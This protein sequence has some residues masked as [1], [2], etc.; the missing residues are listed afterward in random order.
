MTQRLLFNSC[1]TYSPV[2]QSG[3][4]SDLL[5]VTG[6]YI[7]TYHRRDEPRNSQSEFI[8]SMSLER[9]G[10]SSKATLKPRAQGSVKRVLST[11]RLKNKKVFK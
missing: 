2:R 1:I 3:T 5:L 4:S 9:Q 11:D 7:Y 10:I 8:H 6:A